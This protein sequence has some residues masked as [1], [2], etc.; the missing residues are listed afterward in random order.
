MRKGSVSAVLLALVNLFLGAKVIAG[1]AGSAIKELV[2]KRKISI[3]NL[4][5][6]SSSTSSTNSTDKI[7]MEG[8]KLSAK[9][10]EE[11]K[12][13]EKMK[14]K[15]GGLPSQT[16][17]NGITI[18]PVNSPLGYPYPPIGFGYWIGCLPC[19][20]STSKS[21]SSRH[22]SFQ[23]TPV[24]SN[25]SYSLASTP[26][27]L[28]PI[29]QPAS[30]QSS[31]T[32]PIRSMPNLPVTHFVKAVK[33]NLSSQNRES[34]YFRKVEIG[35]GG[36]V[37]VERIYQPVKSIRALHWENGQ[38][39][40]I[41]KTSQFSDN[42]I[43]QKVELAKKKKGFLPDSTKEEIFLHKNKKGEGL[44]LKGLSS[45]RLSSEFLSRKDLKSKPVVI[46]EEVTIYLFPPK[47]ANG[48][49]VVVYRTNRELIGKII[50]NKKNNLKRIERRIT[51][52]QRVVDIQSEG[53]K[54]IKERSFGEKKGVGEFQKLEKGIGRWFSSEKLKIK[55]GKKVQN[56]NFKVELEKKKGKERIE[57]ELLPIGGEKILNGMGK[58]SKQILSTIT[59]PVT[60]E[61]VLLSHTV[62]K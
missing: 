6:T 29:S 36:M 38:W 7:A 44:F 50:E 28:E 59:A 5:P 55:D 32:T 22:R 27:R 54:K 16:E 45:H 41:K 1:G 4:S 46:T 9:V 17:K 62:P 40:E 8:L 42:P 51:T 12:N 43:Y 25:P 60:P 11:Q 24:H 31:K 23:P 61:L 33:A 14:K 15:V 48:K 57:K 37:V 56:Q 34:Y 2:Q 10:L 49:K 18:L 30:N 39:K 52:E 26:I 47:G 21:V 13:G 58:G 3:G 19:P 20:C 53:M 35:V